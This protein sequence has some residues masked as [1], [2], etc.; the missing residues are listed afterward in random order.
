MQIVSD[1]IIIP[2][3]NYEIVLDM[4]GIITT[5]SHEYVF[6]RE[7]HFGQYLRINV[8]NNF[9]EIYPLTKVKEEWNN[10]G[11]WDVDV[12]RTVEEL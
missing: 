7:W 12:K 6:S 10:F 2:N 4:A 5:N 11:K 1:K 8:D 3:E 9:D